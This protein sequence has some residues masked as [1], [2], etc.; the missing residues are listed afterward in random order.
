ME[1]YKVYIFGIVALALA[2]ATLSFQLLSKDERKKVAEVKFLTRIYIFVFFFM[3]VLMLL[4]M[5]ELYK[6]PQIVLNNNA[7]YQLVVNEQIRKIALADAQDIGNTCYVD[8][9]NQ[10]YLTLPQSKDWEEPKVQ[11]G[12]LAYLEKAGLE[13]GKTNVESFIK[14]NP[15]RGVL[16]CVLNDLTVKPYDEMM[17]CLQQTLLK[18]TY[19][20]MLK[21]STSTVFEYGEYVNVQISPQFRTPL[22]SLLLPQ[23]TEILDSLNSD[24]T[25][26]SKTPKYVDLAFINYLNITVLDKTK[27]PADE[28][29]ITLANYFLKNTIN[30]S[31]NAEK[32]ISNEKM[33]LFTSSFNFENARI[34]GETKDFQIHRWVRMIEEPDKMYIIEIA[35]C[36]ETDKNGAIWADQKLM[37]ESFNLLSD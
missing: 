7:N 6:G 26:S 1:T 27:I 16:S 17:T 23:D 30:L 15:Y 2:L 36:P 3:I 19:G 14:W 12:L 31:S 8:A 4:I 24:V 25:D 22:T 13:T 20:L 34:D 37:F 11:S 33:M 5:V 29:K 10:F 28:D 32:I 35:Y 18:S 21:L 9:D